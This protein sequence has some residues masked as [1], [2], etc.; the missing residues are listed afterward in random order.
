MEW[1]LYGVLFLLLIAVLVGFQIRVSALAAGLLVYHFAPLDSLLAIGDFISMSGLTIPTLMLFIIWAVD[2]TA[3]E[4]PDY[5]W[6]VRLAQLLLAFGFFLSG[7]MKLR[8]VGWSWYTGAN[9]R[10][11][12]LATWSLS[13]RP[14][15]IWLATHSAAA[16]VV[17][18]GSALLDSLVIAAVFWRPLRWIVLVMAV[19]ALPVRSIVFGYH[20]LAG[21][22][23]LVFVD[24]DLVRSR[25]VDRGFLRV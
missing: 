12:A 6:P 3:S 19:V 5:R 4:S 1:I 10:Q 13:A 23:L 21:P 11:L 15:A 9:V 24:W 7:V 17:A 8:Y 20:G 18:I 22:L 2:A 16:W 25:C 14:A